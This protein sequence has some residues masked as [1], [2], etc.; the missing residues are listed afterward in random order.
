MTEKE[1]LIQRIQGCT[2]PVY[3]RYGFGWKG[4]TWSETSKESLI[5]ALNAG[6][7]AH[8]DVCTINGGLGVNFYSANDM[9]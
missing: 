8:Y 9:L 5:A 3:I 6:R 1:T 4:A 7:Y 2:T